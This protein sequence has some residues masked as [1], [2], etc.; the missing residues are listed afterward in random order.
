MPGIF[1]IRRH[2]TVMWDWR[3]PI[4]DDLTIG[5]L[6][7]KLQED[8]QIPAAE[9]TLMYEGR[10]LEDSRCLVDY[11]VKGDRCIDLIVTGKHN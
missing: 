1:Y 11:N 4:E 5:A 9:Q 10:P 6:K 2:G 8:R 3:Y 7:L